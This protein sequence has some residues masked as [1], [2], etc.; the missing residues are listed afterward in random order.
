MPIDSYVAKLDAQLATCGD[1]SEVEFNLPTPEADEMALA[2][3]MQEAF[4]Q[5]LSL[6]DDPYQSG[7]FPD[8]G[9][10]PEQSVQAWQAVLDLTNEP[11][12]QA[13]LGDLLWQL[14]AK[15][16]PDQRAAIASSAYEQLADR[17][18]GLDAKNALM[19]ALQLTLAV[20]CDRPRAAA[21]VAS[22]VDRFDASID[23]APPGVS[24]GYLDVL[25]FA[26]PDLRSV[27]L[28]SRF[29]RAKTV[30]AAQTHYVQ[31]LID[32]Q[33]HLAAGDVVQRAELDRESVGVYLRA[34][35]RS[36]GLESYLHL[37]SAVI[38]AKNCPELRD[39]AMK[40]QRAF[41][42][43]SLEMQAIGV[44]QKFDPEVLRRHQD[45]LVNQGN[46]Y[47]AMEKLLKLPPPSGREEANREEVQTLMEQNALRFAVKM[48]T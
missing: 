30:Y 21:L 23:N 19:R 35:E 22:A 25:V 5:W 1:W 10:P 14:R 17:W 16:R 39:I 2:D 46:W 12:V 47:Q 43:G 15:P 48:S 27:D 9:E 24:F 18:A 41:D 31:Q 42:L 33:K 44:N 4:S 3:A 8:L 32:L 34:A 11:V 36:V 29:E 6:P 38:S 20:G 28:A 7:R 45:F 13:R 26:P 40:R 37:Q